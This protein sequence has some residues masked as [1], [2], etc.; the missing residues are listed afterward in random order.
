MS[1]PES[2][3][4]RVFTASWGQLEAGGSNLGDTAILAAQLHDLS[5]AGAEVGVVSADPGR[6]RELFPGIRPFSVAGGRAAGLARGALWADTVVV[7]G[8]E[9]AQDVSS[10]LYSPFNLL[11][12]MLA[13]LFGRRSFAWGI[14]IGQGRELR[15]WT[16]RLLRRWLGTCRGV[17]T[18]DLPTR[19]LLLELG[20]HPRRVVLAADSA[21]SLAEAEP[22]G[23]GAGR[24]LLAAAPRNVLNRRGRLLPLELRRKLGLH[25]EPDPTSVRAAWAELLDD[26]LARRGGGVLMLP[27]H[28][29]SL[30]NADDDE[31]RAVAEMMDRGGRVEMV[32]TTRLEPAMDALYRCRAMV[33]VPLHGSILAVIAGAVPVAAPYATKGT[34]F[35]QQAGLEELVLPPP[36][37]PGWAPHAGGMLESVWRDRDSIRSRMVARRGELVRRGRLNLRHFLRTCGG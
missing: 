13:R 8:G 19:E 24:E 23:Q 35:M 37:T 3:R 2:R 10:L 20:L 21:F 14:G 25:S 16:R 32:D 1:A 30:S 7:G 26:H 33:T 36:G 6:T 27:F 31:C 29:G 18:R 15:P 28:T 34:R 17:T 9:L 4:H 12:L 5:S 22:T 11:P